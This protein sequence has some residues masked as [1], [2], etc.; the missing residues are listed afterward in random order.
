MAIENLKKDFLLE[1]FFR[2]F[3][4]YRGRA[5]QKKKKGLLMM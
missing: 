4:L 2:S 3:W 5:A 1:F